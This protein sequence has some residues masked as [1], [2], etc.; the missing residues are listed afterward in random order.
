MFVKHIFALS[1][2][3]K[4]V[5]ASDVLLAAAVVIRVFATSLKISSSFCLNEATAV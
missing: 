5:S 1:K 4:H 2:K 3:Q